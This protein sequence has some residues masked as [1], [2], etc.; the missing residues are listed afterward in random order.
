[1]VVAEGHVGDVTR[2]DSTLAE[3]VQD[4]RVGRD[5]AGV[6]HDD[7]LAVAVVALVVIFVWW[8]LGMPGRP[9]RSS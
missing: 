3:R 4:P 8:R 7:R 5:E 1:M 6:G 2:R 9:R